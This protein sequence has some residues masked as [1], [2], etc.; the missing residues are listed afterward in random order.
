[1][2]ILPLGCRTAPADDEAGS[3]PSPMSA[4]FRLV[5]S[6]SY[7]AAASATPGTGSEASIAVAATPERYRQ[8]WREH[9]DPV[10]TPPPVDFSR[11]SAVILLLGQRST[12]GWGIEPESVTVSGD[13]AEVRARIV[14]PE[15]GGIVT[16]AF[17]APFAVIAVDSPRLRGA[18]LLDGEG[19]VVAR[20]ESSSR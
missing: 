17:S 9:V 19:E 16:M 6:G 2:L 20:S 15:P 5:R 8:L 4:G 1:M 14:R 11:E 12:G 3:E 10:S 18:V 7:A 13:A